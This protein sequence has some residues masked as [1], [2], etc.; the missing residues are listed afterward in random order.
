VNA[1]VGITIL[2]VVVVVV[3]VILPVVFLRAQRR[4]TSRESVTVRGGDVVIDAGRGGAP[5]RIPLDRIGTVLVLPKRDRNPWDAF[6][7][8]WT[9]GGLLILDRA[10][11][12]VGHIVSGP[13]STLPLEEIADTIPA[14][15]HGVLPDRHRGAFKRSHPGALRFGQLWGLSRWAALVTAAVIVLGPLIAFLIY[16]LVTAGTGAA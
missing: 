8:I 3:F 15:E 10:G 12:V 16:L 9:Y 5:R 6:E 14:A 2:V 1:G 11:H 13:G 4:K 7:G